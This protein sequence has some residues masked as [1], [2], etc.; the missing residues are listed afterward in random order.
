M[1]DCT[2]AKPSQAK[3]RLLA[4]AL[5]QG[6]VLQR[7]QI[8]DGSATVK[9][10]DYSVKR[11]GALTRFLDDGQLPIDNSWAVN[12]I[13]PVAIGRQNWYPQAP[14]ERANVRQPT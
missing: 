6:M 10:Q 13:R 11:L 1:I 8:T 5:Y 2:F 3:T 7:R 12:Q 4:D 14:C 9:A